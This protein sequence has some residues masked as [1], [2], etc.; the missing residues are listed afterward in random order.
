MGLD[1]YSLSVDLTSGYLAVYEIRSYWRHFN[2][3][4]IDEPAHC[5][6]FAVDRI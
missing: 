6:L 3:K 2:L 5:V 1:G 4:G